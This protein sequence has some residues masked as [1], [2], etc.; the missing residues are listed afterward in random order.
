MTHTYA[1]LE[2]PNTVYAAIRKLLEAANYQHAFDGSDDAEVIDMHGIALKSRGGTPG[3][4][5]TVGTVLSNRTEEGLVELSMNGQL[6]QMDLPK[7]REVIGMLQGAV[8]AAISDA[9]MFKFLTE[10]IG[11]APEK[12]G[13][14]LLD[15]REMR[16]GSREIVRPH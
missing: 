14:A 9:L 4:D 12:A 10:R 11:L 2:V 3:T 8:E 1:V 5:I 15:F 6:A 7:A 13:A 16:Q